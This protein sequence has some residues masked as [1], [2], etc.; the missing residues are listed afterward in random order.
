MK[1]TIEEIEERTKRQR[2]QLRGKRGTTPFCSHTVKQMRN[3]TGRVEFLL[4][5]ISRLQKKVKS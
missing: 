5:E 2:K 4:K 1:H 3:Y